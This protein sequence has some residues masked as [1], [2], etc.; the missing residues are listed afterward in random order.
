MVHQ[1]TYAGGRAA[2]WGQPTWAI[3]TDQRDSP[4]FARLFLACALVYVAIYAVEG[5]IRY[6]L[7]LVGADDL[8]LLRDALILV[9]LGALAWTQALRLRLHPA[10]PVAAVLLAF[11]GL[12]MV[13]TMGS[14]LGALFG[15]KI[16][17]NLLFGF[18]V[19]ASLLFP[20]EKTFRILATIWL[21]LV[22]GIVL[23]KFV[24][25]FPWVGIRDQVGPLTVD[26]S[27]NW[28]ISNPMFRRVAGFT[29]AS[30]AA[31]MILP[32]VSIVLLGRIR[33]RL[34]RAAVAAMSLGALFLTTQKGAVVAFAAVAASL[35]LGP[36]GRLARLRT[37]FLAFLVVAVALPLVGSGLHLA[38]GEGVFSME[39][40]NLRF[41][42]TWPDAWRWIDRHQMSWLGV[43]L[44]GIGGPQRLYAPNDVNPADNLAILLYAYF[45]IFA[46]L[47]G[48]LVCVLALR[49]VTGSAD[50]VESA[51][52]IL[53]YA[54]GYGM[55]VSVLE[56]QMASLFVG[57]ALGVLIRETAAKS[58]FGAATGTASPF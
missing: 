36:A 14:V 5:P 41:V 49:P 57:A 28:D 9:P 43:G 38:H 55:V 53:A 33:G 27:K 30:T 35:C 51:L 46:V 34:R 42:D 12:V 37:V 54:A 52:A 26:V 2:G 17:I 25:A 16:L 45:G 1:T 44:G 19:A 21:V 8:I 56:D 18:F 39:S 32:C 4:R 3:R 10:F 47:Y 24:M 7:Y 15:A 22:V 20:D 48:G 58:P 13:G 6:G 29:R 11:H 50:R 23:D 40:L 31:A